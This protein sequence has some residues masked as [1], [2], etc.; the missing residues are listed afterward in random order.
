MRPGFDSRTTQ[1]LFLL[2]LSPFFL[3]SRAAKKKRGN[4]LLHPGMLKTKIKVVHHKI[5][6]AQAKGSPPW[7]GKMVA[8]VVAYVIFG[9]RARLRA[10]KTAGEKVS[11]S[12]GFEPAR[13]TPIAFEAIAVT[14]WL[15]LLHTKKEI[16]GQSCSHTLF[17]ECGAN[18]G[19]SKRKNILSPFAAIPRWR[20]GRVV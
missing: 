7:G 6:I 15:R 3:F 4:C 11:Q 16:S 18:S 2:N 12:A 5:Q 1:C 20:D 9:P 14:T 17:F 8:S 13:V 19:Q 10:Q